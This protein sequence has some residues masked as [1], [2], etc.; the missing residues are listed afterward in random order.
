MD[1]MHE[2]S[3]RVHHLVVW[4]VMRLSET[5][6]ADMGCTQ[7]ILAE[8]DDYRQV[9]TWAATIGSCLRAEASLQRMQGEGDLP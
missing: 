1:G 2:V 6:R 8:G 4:T 7:V 3:L 9:L 5:V